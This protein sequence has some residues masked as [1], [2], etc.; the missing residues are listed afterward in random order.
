MFAKEARV[1]RWKVLWC[2]LA[3]ALAAAVCGA[4]PRT[5]ERKP[6]RTRT[7]AAPKKVSDKASALLPYKWVLKHTENF[8]GR[9]INP[10]LWRRIVGRHDSGADWQRNIS[11]RGDLVTV[12]DGVLTL[13]GVRNS[14]SASDPRRV[15]AGGISTKGLFNM[16]Y[17]KIEARIRLQS[18]KGAWPAVWLMPERPA[19]HWPDCGE[20]D[21]LERLNHD[22]FVYQTV[23]SAWSEAHPNNPP[24]GGK[25]AIKPDAWNVYAL[26][27]MP[28]RIVWYVNGKATHKYDKLTDDPAKWPWNSPFY[29]MFDMQLGGKWVGAVDEAQLPVAMEVDWVKFYELRR[30]TKRVSVFERPKVGGG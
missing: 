4:T 21:V 27:W 30:G 6:A 7:T 9:A 16:T 22:P 25:G 18:A 1:K 26:E 28:E 8:D 15:L 11:P 23:H 13:W 24:R 19:A 29:L 5:A 12:K 17:G 14:D 20:I 10:K 3:S 2:V